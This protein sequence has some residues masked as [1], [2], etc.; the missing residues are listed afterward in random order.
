VSNF[1]YTEL[2]K[3]KLT[4]NIKI[5]FVILLL[6]A[7]NIYG[8]QYYK[9]ECDITIKEKLSENK[10]SILKGSAFYNKYENKTRFD[11]SFPQRES[12][13]ITKDSLLKVVNDITVYK[14]EASILNDYS[15][16]RLFLDGTLKNYGMKKS[17][18]QITEVTENNGEIRSTWIPQNKMQYEFGKVIISQKDNKLRGIAF[19][20]TEGDLISKQVFN[21]YVNLKGLFFPS[22]IIQISYSGDKERY[23]L[24]NFENIL[25]R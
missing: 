3:L 9:I 6:I 13:I 5:F 18:F 20:N 25:L 21:N 19:F 16:F 14:Q 7:E 11:F 10:Y 4:D 2:I 1:K 15:I 17:L 8:Q 24:I 22:Y 12:W 23:R